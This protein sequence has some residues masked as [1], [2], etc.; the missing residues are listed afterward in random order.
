MMNKITRVVGY[1]AC[2]ESKQLQRGDVKP[3]N[4]LKT[5]QLCKSGGAKSGHL[6]IDPKAI[7]RMLQI[8]CASQIVG[9]KKQ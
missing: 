5:S 1:L 6:E 9:R 4:I 3:K 2:K 8:T 7:M